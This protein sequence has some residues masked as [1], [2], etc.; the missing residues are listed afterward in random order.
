MKIVHVMANYA[1]NCASTTCQT[2]VGGDKKGEGNWEIMRARQ[3]KRTGAYFP[4]GFPPSLALSS[5]F[6]VFM[7][8]TYQPVFEGR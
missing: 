7:Q 8:S 4:R 2:L 5:V 3:W 6:H 1:T